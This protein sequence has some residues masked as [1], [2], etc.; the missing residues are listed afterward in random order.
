MADAA[1]F[2]IIIDATG[3]K[4]VNQLLKEIKRER[5]ILLNAVDVPDECDFYFS[6]LLKYK[7]LKVAVSSDGASPTITQV[8]RDKLKEYLPKTLGDLVE[9][10]SS[11]REIGIIDIERTKDE[12]HKLF[13]KV[14]LVGC[15]IG[16]PDLFTIKAYKTIQTVDVVFYDNLITEEILRLVPPEVEKILCW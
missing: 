15:G 16:D 10:K 11:E 12:A 1:D 6:S 9:Q 14:Y 7:N 5:F 13:G 3:S 2:N 8:V 4:E